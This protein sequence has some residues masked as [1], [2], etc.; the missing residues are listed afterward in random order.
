[1]PNIDQNDITTNLQKLSKPEL[2]KHL[3]DNNLRV[4]GN[5]QSLVERLMSIMHT[6]T[7]Q[8][9]A[10]P[11]T[12]EEQ[13]PE[14]DSD[15]DNG[16]AM[17]GEVREFVRSEIQTLR[18][19]VLAMMRDAFAEMRATINAAADAAA[20]KQTNALH[21]AISNAH[22]DASNN[23]QRVGQHQSPQHIALH[24]TQPVASSNVQPDDQPAQHTTSA[25]DAQQAQSVEAARNSGASPNAYVSAP[26]YLLSASPNSPPRA[27]LSAPL[28]ASASASPHAAASV[29]QAPRFASSHQP[30]D[31]TRY[32]QYA[33]THAA[34]NMPEFDPGAMTAKTKSATA[35]IARLRALQAPYKWDDFLMLEAAQRKLRGQAKEWNDESPVVY[36]TFAQFEADLLATYPSYTTQAD[37]LEDSVAKARRDRRLGGL[38]AAHDQYRPP[39]IHTRCRSR[40]VHPKTHQPP[41]VP[42]FH[43]LC[44]SAISG[45]AAACCDAIRS[46]DARATLRFAVYCVFDI[47]IDTH[48]SQPSTIVQHP[49]QPSSANVFI[50]QS[51]TSTTRRGHIS[52]QLAIIEYTKQ[53]EQQCSTER[54]IR[55]SICREPWTEVLELQRSRPHF[56][57]VLQAEA[58]VCQLPANRPRSSRLQVNRENRLS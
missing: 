14:S 26:S 57:S 44:A 32:Q 45:R 58:H 7:Q 4:T 17:S 15:S 40:I 35:F 18:T 51:A 42:Y 28:C 43:R 31:F 5:K 52:T 8:P 53:L 6:P 3:R 22:I 48:Q 10:H 55:T 39:Y 33:V 41:A 9:T 50:Q 49:K 21:N 11:A 34:D 20:T 23:T 56:S 38:R 24:I 12:G 30:A 2:Q 25:P 16:A 36:A 13:D 29:H 46:E 1:M 27:Q 54:H 37:V 47:K 19:D